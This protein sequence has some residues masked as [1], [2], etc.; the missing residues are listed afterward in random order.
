MSHLVFSSFMCSVNCPSV[1][2]VIPRYLHLSVLCVR[3]AYNVSFI[4][5]PVLTIIYFVFFGPKLIFFSYST[6]AQLFIPFLMSSALPA[7][8]MSSI[9]TG[10]PICCSF[11]GGLPFLIVYLHFI[12]L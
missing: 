1:D 8:A 3:R 9:N 6:L 5:L 7:V 11:A 10:I 12:F 4:S 2:I